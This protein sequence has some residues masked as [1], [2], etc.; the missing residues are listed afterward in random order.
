MLSK[1][2]LLGIVPNDMITDHRVDLD[3]PQK[4][5]F[6]LQHTEEENGC[7]YRDRKIDAVF[8]RREDC[9]DNPDN[10]YYDL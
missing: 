10:E 2:F 9:D 6:R 8:D 5:A 1:H 3:S 4:S 7:G